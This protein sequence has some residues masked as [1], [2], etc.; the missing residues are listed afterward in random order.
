MKVDTKMHLVLQEECW[1][2][3][4]SKFTVAQRTK[5]TVVVKYPSN[6]VEPIKNLTVITI[7]NLVP[8]N[9]MERPGRRLWANKAFLEKQS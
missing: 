3:R 6:L 5:S 8:D 2:T 4:K 1:M 9:L 7:R